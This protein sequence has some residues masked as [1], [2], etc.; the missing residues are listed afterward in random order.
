MIVERAELADEPQLFR[1][2]A[3][4]LGISRELANDK[5]V[6]QSKDRPES[7]DRWRVEL[8]KPLRWFGGE[9]AT[10]KVTPV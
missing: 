6:K 8:G 3:H 7:E 1:R 10:V 4:E 2:I 5:A 9:K